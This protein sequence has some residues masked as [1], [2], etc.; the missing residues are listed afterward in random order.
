VL[1]HW[2]GGVQG[3]GGSSARTGLGTPSAAGSRRD[4]GSGRR[5]HARRPRVG[6][7]PRLKGAAA[8]ELVPA[9]HAALHN[10][11]Y[12]SSHLRGR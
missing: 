3:R 8:H 2:I 1:T 5:S 6:A 7:G 12:S 4:R 10:E 9:V 11:R